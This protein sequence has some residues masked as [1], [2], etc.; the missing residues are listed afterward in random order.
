M[1][2]IVLFTGS[3]VWDRRSIIYDALDQQLEAAESLVLYHGAAKGADRIADAWA[4]ERQVWQWPTPAVWQE[5]ADGWCP[6]PP[7]CRPGYCIMAGPRRNQ[8]MLELVLRDRSLQPD[9]A[10][11]CLAVKALLDKTLQRG[12]T[13]DMM[14]RALGAE[15]DTWQFNGNRW[16]HW[17]AT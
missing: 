1:R 7:R 11:I 2:T 3:R 16:V 9:T 10:V 8:L 5:H 6:S 4:K 14:T 13:E 12:G 17:S 15:I